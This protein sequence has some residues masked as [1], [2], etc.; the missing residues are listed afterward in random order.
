MTDGKRARRRGE[1]GEVERE[2]RGEGVEG[3]A[4]ALQPVCFRSVLKDYPFI[5]T[6]ILVSVVTHT[7]EVSKTFISRRFTE[8][9]EETQC[10]RPGRLSGLSDNGFRDLCLW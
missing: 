5:S 3:S 10:S 8:N 6:H 7:R 9:Y 1:E 4:R 2:A